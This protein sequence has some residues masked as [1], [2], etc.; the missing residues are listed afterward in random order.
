[1]PR[2]MQVVTNWQR[3]TWHH[4][5]V[6]VCGRWQPLRE[7]CVK[8]LQQQLPPHSHPPFAIHTLHTHCTVHIQAYIY[9]Y[10]S[11]FILLLHCTLDCNTHN[12]NAAVQCT[13]CRDLHMQHDLH[14]LSL[15]HCT[16]VCSCIVYHPHTALFC[17]C[18]CNSLAAFVSLRDPFACTCVS[19]QLDSFCFTVSFPVPFSHYTVL[20]QFLSSPATLYKNE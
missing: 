19:V 20:Y 16:D 3:A 2:V 1:M 6:T 7:P 12:S 10:T 9:R 8:R 18:T 15:L 4:S 17:F 11:T 13:S 14:C 5:C